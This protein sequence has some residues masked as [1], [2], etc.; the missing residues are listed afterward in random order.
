VTTPPSVHDRLHR[1]FAAALI[2]VAGIGMLSLLGVL[3]GA[4][5]APIAAIVGRWLFLIGLCLLVGASF[6]GTVIYPAP[7]RSLLQL[8]AAAWL[9][10][11]LGLAVVLL[12]L[13][14]APLNVPLWRVALLRSVPLLAAGIAIA[15][16]RGTSPPS[17]RGMATIGIAA[18]AAMLADV[19]TSHISASAEAHPQHVEVF[20][21]WLHVVGVGTWVGGLAA[22]LVTLPRQGGEAIAAVVRRFSV[23]AGIGIALVAVTGLIRAA[24][25]LGPLGNLLTTDFGRL[26]VAKSVLFALLAAMGA[27]QRL[28]SVPAATRW[29]GPLRRI[30][31]AELAVGTVALLLAAALV[32]VP[33]PH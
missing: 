7:Q 16:Q 28:L 9:A 14:G 21:H 4:T 18:A 8:A 26:L 23:T 15:A 19:G 29:L 25:E 3:M 27:G 2:A 20:V 24:Q 5:T 22:L 10:A 6:V 31:G 11:S 13:V 12:A 1:S 32:N 30:G 17:M 33:P